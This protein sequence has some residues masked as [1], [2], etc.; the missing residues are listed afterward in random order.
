MIALVTGAAGWLGSRL[1]DLLSNGAGFAGMGEPPAF[2]NIRCLVHRDGDAE[3][4]AGRDNV[5][6]FRGDIA[7]PLSLTPF[8]ADS[9]GAVVFHCAGIIHPGWRTAPFHAVN[10][11]GTQNLLEAANRAQV[12]R[13]VHVSSNSPIGCNPSREHL[14]D[15][16]APYDP[17][18]GYGHSKMLA[19]QAVTA[20]VSRGELD[21]VILRP[22]WFYGPNQPSRQTLFFRMVRDGA[23]PLLG[24]GGQRRSMAYVDNICQGL[25]R[26]A[27]SD[28]ARGQTYWIADERPYEVREIIAT[29]GEVLRTDF[30]ISVA[31]TTRRLPAFVGDVAY[32]VDYGLQSVGLYAQKI[33]VFSEMNKNIACSIDKARRELGYE[34]AIAL[35]EGMRRSIAW[36][37]EHGGLDA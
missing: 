35:R 15:E 13:F 4:L 28:A 29:V 2:R 36:V 24:D 3:R 17:Y 32:A 12:R 21:A 27:T 22:P 11:I 5:T 34:P 10:A 37:L 1:V 20:V 18:M 33:H 8:F 25:C 23:F 30:G 26:A 6:V 31:K 9:E 7:D 19:E 14:F 16:A